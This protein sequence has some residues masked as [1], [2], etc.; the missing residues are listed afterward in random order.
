MSV[1]IKIPTIN[2]TTLLTKETYVADD[3][4]I[5]I[6]IPHY[7]G[8]NSD[9]SLTDFDLFL[10]GEITKLYN[11]RVTKLGTVA[12]NNYALIEV[13]CMNVEELLDRTFSGAAYLE[14]FNLPKLKKIGSYA[15]HGTK[16]PDTSSIFKTITEFKENSTNHFYSCNKLYN[17]YAPYFP[18]IPRACFASCGLLET[19]R[20][21]SI[22]EIMDYGFNLNYSLKTIILPMD[23]VCTLKTE[24]AF[25]GCYH[26][27]GTVDSKYNPEGL[28]DAKIYVHPNRVE[29]YKN[30]SNWSVFSDII[31]SIE[32]YE[33][34]I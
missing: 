2:G 9:N 28:K 32:E 18:V 10:S 6:G 17:V 16:L 31:Y 23:Y 5:T 24:N 30:A 19:V 13:D 20:F 15:F 14:I 7:D 33:G 8:G 29:E 4:T 12:C 21:D 3:I 22:T 25:T 34:V 1:E 27:Y 11:P 26:L